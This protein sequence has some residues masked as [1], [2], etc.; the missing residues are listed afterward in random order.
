MYKYKK[1]FFGEWVR[2]NKIKRE[3]IKRVLGTSSGNNLQLWL[4]EKEPK[5][6]QDIT[7]DTDDR[8]WLPLRHILKICNHYGLRLADFIEN[9]D[10]PESRPRRPQ[11][12]TTTDSDLRQ[13][14]AT[15]QLMQ[16]RID[17]LQEIAALKEQ[18]QQ[19]EQ[20]IKEKTVLE[21]EKR[22]KD[23]RQDMQSIISTQEETI[24]S[25]RD[26]VNT[27]RRE[28]LPGKNQDFVSEKTFLPESDPT[29]Y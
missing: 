5:P 10:E 29:A 24:H 20:Q 21:Y 12:K 17:H 15:Q 1:D 18:H 26:Q 13:A 14:S 11:T 9:A 6:L 8:A 22:L 25:L 19:M 2:R 3:E 7:K 28:C 4:G 23:L 27:L 16:Q